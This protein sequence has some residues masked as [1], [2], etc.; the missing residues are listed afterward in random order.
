MSRSQIEVDPEL[1]PM[2]WD[3]PINQRD[4]IRCAYLKHGSCQPILRTYPLS[5][6]DHPRRFQASWFQLFPYWLFGHAERRHVDL[7]VRKITGSQITGGRGTSGIK[8][9]CFCC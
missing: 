9:G 8:L 6:D 3:F 2:I 5:N 4:E 1:Q 7:V